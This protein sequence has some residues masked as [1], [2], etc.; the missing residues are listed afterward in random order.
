MHLAVSYKSDCSV[1]HVY[2]HILKTSSEFMIRC[3]G[4]KCISTLLGQIYIYIIH[5]GTT[6]GEFCLNMGGSH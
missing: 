4:C 3:F 2:L 6:M 1:I 5:L